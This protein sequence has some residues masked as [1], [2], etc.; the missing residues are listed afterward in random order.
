MTNILSGAKPLNVLLLENDP[1]DAELCLQELRKAGF[2]MRSDVVPSLEEFRLKIEES[3]YDVILAD[4]NLGVSSGLDGFEYLK[5]KGLP[6]PFILVTGAVGDAFA[7]ECIKRGISDYVLKEHLTRVPVAVHNALEE[8]ALRR[9]RTQA[10]KMRRENERR[11]NEDLETRVEERT[12]ELEAANRELQV[13]IAERR[14][15]ANILLSAQQALAQLQL[16]Q[17]LILNSAGDGICGLDASAHC[18]FMNPA[19][20]RM[21]GWKPEALIGKSWDEVWRHTKPGGALGPQEECQILAALKS[22]VLRKEASTIVWRK[23]GS[24]FPVD[25][26]VTPIRSE[27]GQISG[28]VV[29]FHDVTERL[30]LERMK[31]EFISLVSHE[32][33]TPLTAIRSAL[34]LLA[35]GKLCL[36]PGGCQPVIAVGLSNADR[37]VRLVNDILDIGR[38]ESGQV[39]LEKIVCAAAGLMTEAADSMRAGA[40]ALGISLSVI[41]SAATLSA[42]PGRIT[43]VLTNLIDNALKFS[44]RS[45][46]IRLSAETTDSEVVFRVED[47][48][49]GIPAGKLTSVFEK[50]QQ[51]DASDSRERGGTGLG[52]AIC[53]TIVAQHGGHIWAES[54][55]G[56]GSIF[57]F[58]LPAAD[59]APGKE[60]PP[61]SKL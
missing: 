21:L 1:A 39:K 54:T 2:E 41:P 57:S 12:A 29:V 6:I 53:R 50:F 61:R 22:G 11:L 7:V 47:G 42:E 14:R 60:L 51:V 40:E 48:G 32:L 34:G 24:S 43:Q 37:L 10:E 31:D 8:E 30:A 46:V 19:G 56:D 45:S 38:I 15:A 49:R 23:D 58:T 44:P 20:A 16:Q 59:V 18:A 28:A 35:S 17:E 3:D 5:E 4:Y 36:A 26:V 27:P 9:E 52:L 13:E 33:R 25:F 55:L